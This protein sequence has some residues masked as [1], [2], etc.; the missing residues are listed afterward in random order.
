MAKKGNPKMM[1]NSLPLWII[2][3]FLSLIVIPIAF[4][5]AY[6]AP[7]ITSYVA[8]DPDDADAVYSNG[9]TITINL[10]GA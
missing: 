9:D 4:Q 3:V 2:G 10:S 5:D 8:N 7:T 1:K 6:A